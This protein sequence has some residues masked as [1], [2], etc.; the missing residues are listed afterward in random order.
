MHNLQ[1]HDPVATFDFCN[2]LQSVHEDKINPELTF[3]TDNDW[4]E[5]VSIHHLFEVSL[6]DS[7]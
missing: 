6:Q 7:E 1:P 3:F 4:V 2:Y 5:F